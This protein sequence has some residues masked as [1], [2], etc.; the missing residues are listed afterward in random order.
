MLSMLKRRNSHDW[1]S[2]DGI[3]T[4]SSGSDM[5]SLRSK[6]WSSETL[7]RGM[8]IAAGQQTDFSDL[9]QLDSDTD[10]RD[11]YFASW[12]EQNGKK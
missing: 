12:A 2:S 5:K 6:V 1:T 7:V 10:L 8:A 11:A 9:G 4:A 3:T